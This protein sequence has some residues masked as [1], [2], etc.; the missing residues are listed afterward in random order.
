MCV[1]LPLGEQKGKWFAEK[2]AKEDPRTFWY[3][4]ERKI[5]SLTISYFE[6]GVYFSF[7]SSVDNLLKIATSYN[8]TILYYSHNYFH[9]LPTYIAI[10]RRWICTLT[11][12]HSHFHT[13]TYTHT[14]KHTHTH[15]HSHTHRSCFLL[16]SM[17]TP[18]Q[19]PARERT[20]LRMPTRAS[21]GNWAGQ[22]LTT[23][24]TSTTFMMRLLPRAKVASS[25]PQGGQNISNC[26]CEDHEHL[27]IIISCEL[28]IC[29]M[30]WADLPSLVFNFFPHT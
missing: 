11:N 26:V 23:T 20:C 1:L 21:S 28:G 17:T 29:I 8:T 18:H 10:V 13:L 22:I 6:V 3:R 14:H 16:P 30:C 9:C 12:V 15:T 24:R 19:T 2:F 4:D 25:R 27:C 5:V 7:L